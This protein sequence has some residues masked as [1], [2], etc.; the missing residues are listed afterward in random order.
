MN[1]WED[2]NNMKKI[3]DG[4]KNHIQGSQEELSA[5]RMEICNSCEHKKPSEIIGDR[6]GLCGCVLKFKTKSVD[7]TCPDGKW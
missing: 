2:G 5:T 7:S 3:F 1:I 6:C 4:I